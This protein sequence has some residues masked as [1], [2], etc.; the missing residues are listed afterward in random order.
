MNI[1]QLSPSSIIEGRW[2]KNRYVIK[3]K[4]GEGGIA[5]VY[6]GE[7]IRTRQQYAIKVSNDSIS[8]NR[9]YQLLKKFHKVDMIV[10]TYGIDDLK[11]DGETYYYILL[12]YIEGENLKEYCEKNKLDNTI[13]ISIILIIL[14][15]L[16]AFHA[17]EYIVGDLKLENL[18]L[19][20]RNSKLKII[21]LGGVVKKGDCIKEFTPLYDRASWRCGERIAEASYDFF[22]V[23]MIFIK[24]LLKEPINPKNQKINDVIGKL[25]GLSL[26]EELKNFIVEGLLQKNKSLHCPIEK[27][28]ALYDRE[29]NHQRQKKFLL[30]K[31]RID[32]FFG[33]SIL[34]FLTTIIFLFLI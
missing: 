26:D 29:W 7:D 6:L 34:F 27:L 1:P 10:E 19:D 5:T 18:M 31:K 22:T 25:K 33:F 15:G 23:M 17:E 8:I 28:K 14:K 24:L 11:L 21:D 9:E 30:R 2:N 4:I 12:E 20:K 3:E 16:Q 32:L 13:I